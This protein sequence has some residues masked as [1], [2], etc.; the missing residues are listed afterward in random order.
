MSLHK[1]TGECPYCA[2]IF[3]RYP[4]FHPNLRAW[5]EN[6]QKYHPEAHISCAGRGRQDQEDLFVKKATRAHYEKSA[7]N[8]NA[9][10]DI[11]HND[12][13]QIYDYGWYDQVM[14]PLLPSWSSWYGVPEASFHELPHVEV[15][16]WS[17]FAHQGVLKLVEA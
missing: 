9:A 17:S 14:K 13:M 6:L 11:F 8:W 15:A 3:D 7:H 4:G 2:Q 16:D 1:N 5:F 12:T 10:I